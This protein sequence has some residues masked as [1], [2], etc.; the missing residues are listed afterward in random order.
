MI[1][2][3]FAIIASARTGSNYVYEGLNTLSNVRMYH[4]IFAPHYRTAATTYRS[5]LSVLD[6]RHSPGIDSLGLKIF[7]RHL[8]EKE[9]SEMHEQADFLYLHLTRENR[10]RTIVSL[11]LALSTDRWTAK[12]RLQDNE[13]P[14]V[15]L[16]T[17]ELMCRLNK[18]AVREE[19]FRQMFSD[20]S[21]LEVCYER[22]TANP[23]DEF[24]RISN[25]LSLE[26]IDPSR[27]LLRKQN[28][29][30]LDELIENYDEVAILLGET[31]YE[32]YLETQE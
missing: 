20:R 18:M 22:L 24:A 25:F 8:S 29:Q 30:P 19:R 14:K 28:P 17:G 10:L 3:R 26:K 4:E 11:E 6:N 16:D 7:Y 2:Q 13:K 23:I 9:W 15:W 27:I 21:V 1:R 12:R 31:E 5:R 32:G